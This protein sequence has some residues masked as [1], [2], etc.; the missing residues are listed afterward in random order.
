MDTFREFRSLIAAAARLGVERLPGIATTLFLGWVGRELFILLSVLL[1]TRHVLS[2]LAFTTAM[3]V[4]VIGL[5]LALRAAQTGRS[6]YVVAEG[7]AA[8]DVHAST[9]T[10]SR[11]RVLVEA[12]V[13][14]L[15]VYSAWGLTEEHIQ[16]V[17][18]ANI[19][20]YG[21]EAQQYSITFAQWPLYLTI[22][23]VAWALQAVVELT[24]R[25]RGGLPVGIGRALLR[26]TFILTA[27]LGL[28][29]VLTHVISWI[30]TREVWTWGVTAWEG[31]LDLLPDWELWWQQT[32]P[33]LVR[34]LGAGL[35]DF[36]VPGV[37]TMVLLPIVWL[38]LTA[39]IVGWHDVG[40][41]LA[42][43]R[44]T[45]RLARNRER[46]R[47]TRAGRAIDA[48]TGRSPLRVLGSWVASQ[49][50][51]IVPVLQ[52]LR[53][54]MRSGVPLLAAFLLLGALARS[55]APLLESGLFYVLGPQSFADTMRAAPAI[56]LVSELAS[57]LVQIPLYAVAFE[58]AMARADRVT[59]PVEAPTPAP[60][61]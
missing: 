27:F 41:A 13:P 35:W 1:S 3:V 48:A 31:F 22:A 33:E 30:R 43:G 29:S 21:T 7:S 24:L 19:V 16:R 46:F 32:I 51:D 59:G 37:W 55:I 45:G 44:I 61:A 4:W 15:V 5:V 54:L 39:T 10:I 56:G 23:G 49:V 53:L 60:T 58:R 12:V 2:A 26:G 8:V 34:D 9:H 50:D 28:D 20:H 11:R 42:P 17:F 40:D 14:F 47:T 38:A 36:V 25:D 6:S 52:A 18:T 57:W